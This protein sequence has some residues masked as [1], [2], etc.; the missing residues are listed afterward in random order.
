MPDSEHTTIT[1]EMTL[2]QADALTAALDLYTR[3]GLGNLPEIANLA[4]MGVITARDGDNHSE[5][6]ADKIEIIQQILEVAK[7]HL[8]H[9]VN[10]HFGIGNEGV[11]ITPRRAYEVKKVIDKALWDH[12]RPGKSFSVQSDGLTVRYTKDP[13]PLAKVTPQSAP[14]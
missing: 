10:G 11:T 12:R 1:L 13:A 14:T 4:R 6:S 8:G 3:I 9:E 7:V 5:V 2:A